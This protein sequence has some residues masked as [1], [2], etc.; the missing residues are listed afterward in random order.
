MCN[1]HRPMGRFFC[2]LTIVS[3]SVYSPLVVRTYAVPPANGPAVTQVV[4]TV[5]RA[6]GAAAKG[7]VLISWPG[8]T[9]ADGKAV[10]AGSLSVALGNGGAFAA[11]LAPNTGAQPAGAY[12]RVVY[13][14]V[15]KSRRLSTG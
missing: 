10:A 14:L 2:L 13:Q 6:D 9:T 11:G 15:G 5:Y 7:T 3:A 4:D 8:F 12:Y 1:A